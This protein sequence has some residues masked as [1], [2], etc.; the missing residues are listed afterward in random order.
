MENNKHIAD[1]FINGLK[2]FTGKLEQLQLEVSLG[3]AEA[4]D[5]IDEYKKG[6][7]NFLNE[8]KIELKKDASAITGKLQQEA[9]ELE[10]QL[11]LGKMEAKDY[12]SEHKKQ[13]FKT[14]NQIDKILENKLT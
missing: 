8:S 1:G 10:V 13:L 9:E 6:L 5:K 3:K 4:K 2:N 7:K 12:V 14:I 11:E